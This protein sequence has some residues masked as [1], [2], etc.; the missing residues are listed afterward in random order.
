MEN[1]ESASSTEKE[2]ADCLKK[3][4]CNGNLKDVR[5]IN[6]D[7]RETTDRSL[8]FEDECGAAKIGEKVA[9][10]ESNNDFAD[11]EEEDPYRLQMGIRVTESGTYKCDVC[12]AQFPSYKDVMLHHSFLHTSKKHFPCQECGKVFTSKNTWR[13]HNIK[14]HNKFGKNTAKHG[15]QMGLD[16]TESGTYKCD[17]CLDTFPSGMEVRK[18]HTSE[19]TAK[20]HFPCPEC[21]KVF[22]NKRY[23]RHH[24]KKIHRKIG[25]RSKRK[26]KGTEKPTLGI[27]VTN[28]GTYNCDVC[29][30]D[31]PTRND[32]IQ[33]HKSE[34]TDNKHFPCP[35]CSQVFSTKAGWLY[36]QKRV[37]C[38]AKSTFGIGFTESGTYKCDPNTGL[39]QCDV[40][41]DKFPSN[42]EVRHHHNSEHT[43]KKNFPCLYCSKVCTSKK[44]WHFHNVRKHKK[45]TTN[46]QTCK[47]CGDVYP[48]NIGYKAHIEKCQK[49]YI[50]NCVKCGKFFITPDALDTH[51]LAVHSSEDALIKLK[52]STCDEVFGSENARENH[53]ECLKDPNNR[54]NEC[55][56]WFLS[57]DESE[58]HKTSHNPINVSTKCMFECSKCGKQF[59][60]LKGYNAH[61][62]LHLK[63]EKELY[64]CHVCG[65]QFKNLAG[66]KGHQI[67]H[68]KK[69]NEHYICHVCE[70]GFTSQ[71]NL[72]KHIKGHLNNEA[73]LCYKC[74]VCNQEFSSKVMLGV[75]LKRHFPSAEKPYKCVTCEK[76]FRSKAMS[77]IHLK[78]H[79][80][81]ERKLHKCPNCDRRF[82][83][84][85]VLNIH[86][87]QHL[88]NEKMIH[89]CLTCNK[90]FVSKTM[91]NVHKK[92]HIPSK[93][94]PY[95]CR[96][97]GKA[98]ATKVEFN[99]HR[100]QC[101]TL[102]LRKPQYHQICNE[103]QL[104]TNEFNKKKKSVLKYDL[105]EKSR[106]CKYCG[107]MMKTK[108]D[109]YVSMHDMLSAR[110]SNNLIFGINK[111]HN[112]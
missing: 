89:K 55:N 48:T 12:F 68:V 111:V 9:K 47:W 105:D 35:E 36:H 45:F 87:K 20:K 112:K 42:K 46:T 65:K 71:S 96:P 60:T 41:F 77:S 92:R 82:H 62:I 84:K 21:D 51:N 75:H 94:N 32:V 23:W 95:Q 19:H 108:R 28:S 27:D 53:E 34:H 7:M 24:N 16:V 59:K 104:E 88:P 91:L 54:F 101:R 86:M 73:N 109:L 6:S 107:V 102:D 52:C 79:L 57:T 31:F 50:F 26:K 10:I 17:V 100:K 44:M 29:L 43:C 38:N 64:K 14:K 74:E 49:V 83:F 80:P 103:R 66:Y 61:K 56:Q 25:I 22:K 15:L 2:T 18:H 37:K 8:V 97:C 3:N 85:A 4:E 5:V 1:R 30:K 81:S 106:C 39:Y 13:E 93:E 40:C 67:C 99:V 78:R 98:F 33:H 76:K 58:M 90:R 72:N 70:R 11:K 110:F 69:G 63:M